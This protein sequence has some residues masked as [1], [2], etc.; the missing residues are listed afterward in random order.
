MALSDGVVTIARTLEMGE[1]DIDVDPLDEI[2]AAI[3]PTLAYIE[4]QQGTR[5]EKLF[6]AGFGATIRI[7]LDSAFGRT[8]HSGRSDSRNSIRASPVIGPKAAA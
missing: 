8:R 2:I 6:I 7:F 1:S 5:P 4:D 3:Y